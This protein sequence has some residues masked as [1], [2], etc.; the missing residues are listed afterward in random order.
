MSL[1]F[2]FLWPSLNDPHCWPHTSTSSINGTNE[3]SPQDGIAFSS[4]IMRFLIWQINLSNH[5]STPKWYHRLIAP[6][7]RWYAKKSSNHSASPRLLVLVQIPID[8]NPDPKTNPAGAK[9]ID[10]VYQRS[11]SSTPHHHG[12]NHLSVCGPPHLPPN[13]ILLQMQRYCCNPSRI[14]WATRTKNDHCP[15]SID[16]ERDNNNKKW[17]EYANLLLPSSLVYVVHPFESAV[18]DCKRMRLL[19]GR[20]GGGKREIFTPICNLRA[21]MMQTARIRTFFLCKAAH[22][23]GIES[24]LDTFISHEISITCS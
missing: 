3:L 16:M 24:R 18:T 1:H 23:G 10:R 21:L 5:H 22:S 4:K 17:L 6:A 2:I 20:L 19:G 8:K 7:R 14:Y 9:M 13:Q 12:R 11:H 15:Q